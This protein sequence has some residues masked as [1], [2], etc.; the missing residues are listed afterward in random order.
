MDPST[1]EQC[2]WQHFIGPHS[3]QPKNHHVN[4]MVHSCALMLVLEGAVALAVAALESA[5]RWVFLVVAVGVLFLAF[6]LGLTAKGLLGRSG[7][8]PEGNV[9]AARSQS[10]R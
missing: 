2:I 6:W 10:R 5:R 9:D 1:G 3:L 8:N 4:I 7:V